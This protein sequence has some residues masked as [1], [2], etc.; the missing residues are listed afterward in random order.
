MVIR[1]GELHD[2]EGVTELFK[3]FHDESLNEYGVNF[4]IECAKGAWQK[5]YQESLVAIKDGKVIGIIAGTLVS[6][7]LEGRQMFQ[8]LVWFVTKKQRRYGVLLLRA[9][10][11][12]LKS[13]GISSI[14]MSHMTNSKSEKI[15]KLYDKMGYKM[16][17]VHYVKDL[18]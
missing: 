15:E 13:V 18:S 5:H 11:E 8:E 3:E 9:M 6:F 2:T 14:V 1:K 12:K 7:G 4:D 10:E 16:L 17:E